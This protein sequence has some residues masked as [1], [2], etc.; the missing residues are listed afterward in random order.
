MAPGPRPSEGMLRANHAPALAS[1]QLSHPMDETD[2]ENPMN[3][4]LHRK[5]YTS[6]AAW[7]CAA[8]V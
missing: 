4:P 2:L 7:L 6:F 8:A 1:A 5:L 3:W